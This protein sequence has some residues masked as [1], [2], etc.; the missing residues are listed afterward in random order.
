M[1]QTQIISP[2]RIVVERIYKA[3]VL[4]SPLRA[5]RR[6]CSDWA[7]A[8]ADLDL[9]F[10][11]SHFIFFSFALS[12]FIRAS[13]V[14]HFIIYVSCLSCCP[15]CSLQP[16]DHLLALLYVMG[17]FCVFV[18][19]PCDVLGQV[20]YLVV[21]IPDLC[22]LSY[23][24]HSLYCNSLPTSVAKILQIFDFLNL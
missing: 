21:S 16:C 19:F 5:Q 13:F 11:H 22:L 6:H 7:E 18:T 8:Q 12:Y 1:K 14:D 23:S 15:V 2:V 24:N 20:W 4:S 3:K 10:W 9:R 17:F